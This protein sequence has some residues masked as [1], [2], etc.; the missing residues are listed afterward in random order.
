MSQPPQPAGADQSQHIQPQ[1]ATDITYLC[2]GT[3]SAV[4]SELFSN[5]ATYFRIGHTRTRFLASPDCSAEN[6]IRVREPIR[7]RE[8]GHRIMY[9]KRT[10]QSAYRTVDLQSY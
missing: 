2:A 1:K 10:K 9:K 7:C 3:S 8:C 5:M 6:T 4:F